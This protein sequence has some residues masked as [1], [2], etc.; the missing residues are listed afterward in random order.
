VS[1]RVLSTDEAKQAVQQM[2][3]ILGGQLQQQLHQLMSNG[4][5]LADPNKWDGPLAMQYRNQVWPDVKRSLQNIG[6]ALEKLHNE[7]ST[8]LNNI[9]QAGGGN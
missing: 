9:M 5:F 1:T 7:V 8:V 2:K 6:P 4:D 3:G